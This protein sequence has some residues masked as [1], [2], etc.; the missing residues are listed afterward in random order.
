MDSDEEE[1]GEENVEEPDPRRPT[2]DLHDKDEE[3]D[4]D[5]GPPDYTTGIVGVERNVLKNG[6]IKKM[7][8]KHGTDPSPQTPL[9]GDEV[10]GQCFSFCLGLS[11]P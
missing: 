11:C 6:G 2:C 7:V 9:Y 1:K 4:D 8:V 3:E 5:A 10:T